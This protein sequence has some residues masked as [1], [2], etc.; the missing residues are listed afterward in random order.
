MREY[1]KKQ[2]NG[3]CT[4]RLLKKS[5]KSWTFLFY[6]MKIVVIVK[7]REIRSRKE[8]F[9]IETLWQETIYEENR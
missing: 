3:C 2:Y 1:T 4:V 6:E 9:S 5:S 7:E 8:I